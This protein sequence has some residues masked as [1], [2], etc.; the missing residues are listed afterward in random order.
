M[1]TNFVDLA[2]RQPLPRVRRSSQRTILPKAIKERQ[3]LTGSLYSKTVSTNFSSVATLSNG[4]DVTVTITFSHSKK[5][6]LLTPEVYVVYY[7]GSIDNANILPDGSNITNSEWIFTAPWFDKIAWDGDRFDSVIS[8][9][10]RNISAGAS[11]VI[12]LT[13]QAKFIA[14]SPTL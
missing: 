6:D 8:F 2:P 14:G 3:W 9:Y 10:I 13:I 4:E 7:V 1:P 11:Q 5:F 12:A